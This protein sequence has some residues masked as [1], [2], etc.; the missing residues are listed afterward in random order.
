[1]DLSNLT[2]LVTG[3]GGSGVGGGVCEALAAGGATLII[4]DRD[5][6]KATAAAARYSKALPLPAD[7]SD[8]RE[9][10]RMFDEI[11]T[12]VGVI[13]GLVNN[14]GVGLSRYAHEASE[15]DFDRLFSID[16]RGVWLISKFFVQQLLPS[17]RPG[18]IVNISSVH[19]RATQPRY[20]VYAAAK[21]AVEGL[22]RGMA[23][24]L[25]SH[26][27]R[28]NAVAPG[29][30]HAE[31]NRD[32]IKTWAADPDAWVEAFVKDQQVIPDPIQPVDCGRIV[33]FLLSD[34]SR[35]ITGQTVV[36]DAGTTI[37]VHN[38]SFFDNP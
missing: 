28:C 23:F 29:L 24:E 21:A 10:K 38:R 35:T 32:L 5:A 17:G 25:G 14:A 11:A 22:T 4:N 15:A 8:S 18:S 13:N 37:M 33:A 26:R 3:G 36:I 27:I 19:A 1:M 16:V 7:V 9:V 12:K 34:L 2:V 6:E 31:Q 30:V 20:A